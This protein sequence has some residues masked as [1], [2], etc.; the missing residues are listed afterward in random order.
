MQN[1]LPLLECLEPYIG[2]TSIRRLNRI[3]Q[4]MLGMTGRVTMLGI[5]RWTGFGGSYRT[6]QRFFYTALPWATLLW[7]FFREYLWC[8]G[9]TYLLTGDEVVVTKSGKKKYLGWIFVFSSLSGKSVSGLSFFALSLV[10][11]QQRHS[12]PV[13][14]EQTVLSE[15]EKRQRKEKATP[16]TKKNSK[17]HRGKNRGGR[18][19]GSKTKKKTEVVLSAE[20]LRIKGWIMALLKQLEAVVPVSYLLLDGHFGNNK[21]LQMTR[22]LNLHLISKLRHD[23]A[24]Y[25]P[26]KNPDPTRKCRRQ[27]GDKLNISQIPNHSLKNSNLDGDYRTDIYQ[28]QLLHKEF[29]QPLNVVIILK[30]HQTTGQRSHIILFS[31]D[32]QLSYEQLIDYYSLGF[33]IEFNFR[34]AKQFWG[35]E[36][37]MNVNQTAVTIGCQFVFFY[38]QLIPLSTSS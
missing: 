5:S 13:R 23:S 27:Y 38:G 34:D 22:Q 18:P 9:E 21:A 37:F 33:Q 36:D 2:A 28:L 12:F 16:S 14:L 7:V 20:L 17:S 11:V 4:A 30:T 1:I 25:L 24:L 6:I 26:Y 29:A 3:I 10:S 19:P 32:I 8:R 35:L 15:E 31:S